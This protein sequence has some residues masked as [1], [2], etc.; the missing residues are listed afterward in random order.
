M[1]KD[2]TENILRLVIED[3]GINS[4]MEYTFERFEQVKQL[5]YDDWLYILMQIKNNKLALYHYIPF[6]YHCFSINFSPIIEAMTSVKKETK[7]YI[8]TKDGH[9]FLET[10]KGIL[11]YH[12]K[13][14]G[15]NMQQKLENYRKKLL[16]EV[17]HKI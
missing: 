9:D 7:D 8:S 13:L 12:L 14:Y 4:I 15:E 3:F 1:N 5:S 2:I 11:R 16:L 6:V 10:S 17:K